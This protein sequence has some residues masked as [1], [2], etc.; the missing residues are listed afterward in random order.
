MGSL[1]NKFS[2]LSA[3]HAVCSK[4]IENVNICLVT[5]S[6]IN[7]KF[8][9]PVRLFVTGDLLH[10]PPDSLI[11]TM[12]LREDSTISILEKWKLSLGCETTCPLSHNRQMPYLAFE[13]RSA[14]DFL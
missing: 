11:L 14:C 4:V 9:M 6:T 8:T 10:T 1:L 13:S 5:D 12:P 7:F 2:A 3:M